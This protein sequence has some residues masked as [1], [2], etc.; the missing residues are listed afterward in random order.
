MLLTSAYGR[1]TRNNMKKHEWLCKHIYCI[2]GHWHFCCYTVS[3]VL[4]SWAINDV[5]II[6][7]SKL[8]YNGAYIRHISK[9]PMFKFD[10]P[11]RT[12]KLGGQLKETR[13]HQQEHSR[14]R[15]YDVHLLLFMHHPPLDSTFFNKIYYFS[16]VSHNR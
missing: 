2:F 16:G 11:L 4:M 13:E 8:F 6:S 5:S 3:L 15:R 7:M 9:F 10:N 14:V 12:F 1:F